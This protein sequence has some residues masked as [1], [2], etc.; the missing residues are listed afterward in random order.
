[1][2]GMVTVDI[3]EAQMGGAARY[4]AE[5]RRYLA[6]TGCQD[7]QVIGAG[8]QVGPAWL[9]QREITKRRTGRRIAVNNVQPDRGTPAPRLGRISPGHPVR[10]AAAHVQAGENA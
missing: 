6:R 7:V 4:A 8:Q 2:N 9:L 3:A 10:E 1:M 5:L